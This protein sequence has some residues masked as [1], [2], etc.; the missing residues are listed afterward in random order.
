MPRAGDAEKE[1]LELGNQ[2]V[3]NWSIGP[4]LQKKFYYSFEKLNF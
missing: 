2:T 3:G 4:E 1:A